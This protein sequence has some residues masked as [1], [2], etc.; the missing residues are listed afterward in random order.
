MKE[1]KK[2]KNRRC[3]SG[4]GRL[5]LWGKEEKLRSP[6]REIHRLQLT[7][8]PP[9]SSAPARLMRCRGSGL[10]AAQPSTWRGGAAAMPSRRGD[11]DGD[12]GPAVPPWGGRGDARWRRGADA[13]TDGHTDARS[14]KLTCPNRFLVG[15]GAAAARPAAGHGHAW[16]GARGGN[17]GA[18][19]GGGDPGPPLAHQKG[20]VGSAQGGGHRGST[21]AAGGHP[22]PPPRPRPPPYSRCPPRRRSRLYPMQPPTASAPARGL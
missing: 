16:E 4:E 12:G 9:A 13:R 17:S 22:A 20:G 18:W 6:A 21:L 10:G 2:D 15:F 19:E 14:R 8:S 1:R 7:K 5:R 3:H 11:G